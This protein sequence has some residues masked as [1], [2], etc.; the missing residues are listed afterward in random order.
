MVSIIILYA[1]AHNALYVDVFF[2][3]NVIEMFNSFYFIIADKAALKTFPNL[4]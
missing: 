2:I 1:Y 3:E 4:K